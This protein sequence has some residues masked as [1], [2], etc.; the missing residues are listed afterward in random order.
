MDVHDIDMSS[1]KAKYKKY[2]IP[3]YATRY[4]GLQVGDAN[5]NGQPDVLIN[6]EYNG[7]NI[8]EAFELTA[9]GPQKIR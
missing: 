1:N 5:S 6:Y 7:Q 3:F 9:A 4:L 2:K 8:S